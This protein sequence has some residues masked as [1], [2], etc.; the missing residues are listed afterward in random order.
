M[1]PRLMGLF[2][3]SPTPL[4][5]ARVEKI[6]D[7]RHI[8]Y[9]LEADGDLVTD[10]DGHAMWFRLLDQALDVRMQHKARFEAS[11]LL[12]LSDTLQ[13]WNRTKLWPK[14][15]W[16]GVPYEGLF[17][18]ITS[19]VHDYGQGATDAQLDHQVALGLRCNAELAFAL[20]ELLDDGAP[21]LH[22]PDRSRRA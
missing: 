4:T 11:T 16:Q 1:L 14:V 8:P 18:V 13:D 19:L 17:H 15:F 5:R 22:D 21:E 9:Q 6:L 2:A 20:A 3:A 10:F 12:R 7:A